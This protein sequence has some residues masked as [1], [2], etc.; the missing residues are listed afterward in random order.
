M[1][2]TLEMESE[3]GQEES[4]EQI[5]LQNKQSLEQLK[6]LPLIVE[7]LSN[8][9]S[10]AAS[11]SEG[12]PSIISSPVDNEIED[13][14]NNLMSGFNQDHK[15]NPTEDLDEELSGLLKDVEKGVEYGPAL[16]PS[17]AESFLKTVSRPLTKETSTALK[18]NLKLPENA[19]MLQPAR[20]NREIW[21][22]IPTHARLDD[23]RKQQIQSSLGIGISAL[24]QIANCMAI[25]SKLIPHAVVGEI[26]KISINAAN[27]LG[28]QLQDLN[29]KRRLDVKRYINPQYSNICTKE[30][31]Q[32]E[33]LFGDDLA[34]GLK[35]S[36]T[37]AVLSKVASRSSGY[38]YTPY[39]TQ[40]SKRPQSLNYQRSPFNAPRRGNWSQ[41]RG[42]HHVHRMNRPPPPLTPQPSFQRKY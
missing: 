8:K 29:Y 6:R 13:D 39:Q 2:S 5:V 34:E 40:P 30:V 41:P 42:A 33:W 38:R 16:L 32:S 11:G 15:T 24:S 27:I 25:N 10:Q 17:V 23:I 7:E 9:L 22:V 21:K 37:A 26:M 4:L 14:F 20:M 31:P 36:K 35:N 18:N 19:K 1:S 3:N 12:P 28:D